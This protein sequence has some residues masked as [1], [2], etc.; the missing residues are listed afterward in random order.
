M[1]DTTHLSRRLLLAGLAAGLATPALTGAASAEGMGSSL[2]PP[3]R[4]TLKTAINAASPATA[5]AT[6]PAPLVEAARLGGTTGFIVIDAATGQVLEAVNPD[7]R[8]PPASVAKTIT[9]LYGLEKLGADHRFR[10]RILATGPVAN[11]KVQG[12]LILSGGG[13]PTLTTDQLGDLAAALKARGIRGITGQLIAHAGALPGLD[14]LSADQPDH[15]GYNPAL[16]G[17]N[18]NFN[19]VYFEWKRAGAKWQL[20]MDARADRFVPAVSMA[21]VRV[22]DRDK[23]LFTY[24]GGKEDDRWTVAAAALGKGGSRWLPVRHP[25]IYSAEVFRT[26]AAAQGIALPPATISLALPAGASEL[27]ATGSDPL[28]AVLKAMLKHSTNLTAECV[29]LSA[30]GETNLEA[31]G[32]AMSDWARARFGMSSDFHDHSGLGSTSRTTASDMARAILAADRAGSGLRSLLRDVGMRDAKGAPDKGSPVQVLAK[33]GTLNFCSGLA[34]LIVPPEGKEL[35]FAIF[36][37]DV[38]RR[39]AIPMGQR[40]GP[41]GGTA[42]LGRARRLQGQLLSRWATL[43]S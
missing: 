18:L 29:G 7:A 40:E 27:A 15:V 37:A 13:D 12:D 21:S 10:T 36:S 33:T 9:T 19:R 38:K 32:G 25:A 8:L 23:P 17:L 20:S 4:S 31:S 14:R 28:P 1:R 41:P 5:A 16:S 43:Y 30:S 26:L 34:G 39:E 6:D 2:R 11:G 24:E 35:A 3:P 42:W 22:V